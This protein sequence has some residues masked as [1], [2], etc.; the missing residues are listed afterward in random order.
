MKQCIPL[1][2]SVLLHVYKQGFNVDYPL[3]L[4]VFIAFKGTNFYLVLLQLVL[5]RVAA[6]IISPYSIHSADYMYILLL[7]L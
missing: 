3:T 5:C 6:I 7:V 1:L 4:I 2:I